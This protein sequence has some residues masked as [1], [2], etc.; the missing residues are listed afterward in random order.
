MEHVVTLQ[1]V[2]NIVTFI[3][4]GYFAMQVYSFVYAKRDRDFARLLIESVVYSLPIITIVNALWGLVFSQPPATAVSVGYALLTLAVSLA[5][6]FLVA[7][8]RVWRPV[9]A[10]IER[11]GIG[12]P[13]DDFVKA[14][15][16]RVQ[17]DDDTQNAVTVR[18]KSS[19]TFSGTPNRMSRYA[20]GTPSYYYFANLAWFNERTR[21]WDEREG[22]I[23]VRGDEI[24]YIQTKPLHDE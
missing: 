22:G 5:V 13:H 18:L 17:Y 8:L 24:E 19:S 10:V 6:G 21:R 14:Q 1:D 23:I 12:S 20:H 4:P 11:L 7:K 9:V 16:L 3:V 15:L 2:A